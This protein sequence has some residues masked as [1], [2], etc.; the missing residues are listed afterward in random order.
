MRKE[1]RR[2]LVAD[3][4]ELEIARQHYE[5]YFAHKIGELRKFLTSLGSGNITEKAINSWLIENEV[6]DHGLK[7][8]LLQEIKSVSSPEVSNTLL[9]CRRIIGNRYRVELVEQYKHLIEAMYYTD[10]EREESESCQDAIENVVRRGLWING[11]KI[12]FHS[13]CGGFVV[14]DI[15]A[16]ALGDVGLK[17]HSAISFLN[18]HLSRCCEK[19]SKYF[20]DMIYDLK[21]LLGHDVDKCVSTYLEYDR[22][23]GIIML[24]FVQSY[25]DLYKLDRERRPADYCGD[26]TQDNNSPVIAQ[27]TVTF[28]ITQNQGRQCQI[29]LIEGFLEFDDPKKEAV[30]LDRLTQ[31]CSANLLLDE[32][33]KPLLSKIPDQNDAFII[34]D[35]VSDCLVDSNFDDII[36][37]LVESNSALRVFL[38]ARNNEN[39][40]KEVLRNY[41]LLKCICSDQKHKQYLELLKFSHS[42]NSLITKEVSLLINLIELVNEKGLDLLKDIDMIKDFFCSE[43]RYELQYIDKDAPKRVTDKKVIIIKKNRYTLEYSLTATSGEYSG[44][45]IS[46]TIPLEST[47]GIFG[48]EDTLNDEKIK[49][50]LPIVLKLVAQQGHIRQENP[51]YIIAALYT[52]T[53]S[54]I[55]GLVRLL[56]DDSIRAQIP[57]RW[58]IDLAFESSEIASWLIKSEAILNPEVTSLELCKLLKCQPQLWDAIQYNPDQKIYSLLR[59]RITAENFRYLLFENSDLNSLECAKKALCNDPELFEKLCSLK[60]SYPNELLRYFYVTHSEYRITW[61]NQ[62]N[63]CEP[64]L[65][66]H[67]DALVIEGYYRHVFRKLDLLG[68]YNVFYSVFVKKD[69]QNGSELT[70]NYA[71]K[72]WVKVLEVRCKKGWVPAFL[73]DTQEKMHAIIECMS[74]EP[75]L[76]CLFKVNSMIAE[77]LNNEDKKNILAFIRLCAESYYKIEFNDVQW[78]ILALGMLSAEELAVFFRD[79]LNCQFFINLLI[80][81]FDAINVLIDANIDVGSEVIS[82]ILRHAY[83]QM[84]LLL[85]ITVY[86]KETLLQEQFLNIKKVLKLSKDQKYSEFFQQRNVNQEE[87]V[88]HLAESFQETFRQKQKIK[89]KFEYVRNLRAKLLQSH[90]LLEGLLKADDCPEIDLA[91]LLFLETAMSPAMAGFDSRHKYQEKIKAINDNVAAVQEFVKHGFTHDDEVNKFVSALKSQK[92]NEKV[93]CLLSYLLLNAFKNNDFASM[94]I[95]S[96][97]LMMLLMEEAELFLLAKFVC[98]FG[99]LN[100]YSAPW[101][102]FFCRL[103]SRPDIYKIFSSL[104]QFHFQGAGKDINHLVQVSSEL[105]YFKA[106]DYM[107]LLL[108]EYQ[109]GGTRWCREWLLRSNWLDKMVADVIPEDLALTLLEEIK[110]R[111]SSASN[112]FS[113]IEKCLRKEPVFKSILQHTGRHC[114]LQLLQNDSTLATAIIETC[115]STIMR[116]VESDLREQLI[117]MATV[118]QLIYLIGNGADHPEAVR[119]CMLA[120]RGILHVNEE[121]ETIRLKPVVLLGLLLV[122]EKVDPNKKLGS[123]WGRLLSKEQLVCEHLL[124]RNNAQTVVINSSTLLF[125]YFPSS[126]ALIKRCL[127][128]YAISYEALVIS[129]VDIAVDFL[130]TDYC[131]VDLFER[132]NEQYTEKKLEYKAVNANYLTQCEL[133]NVANKGSHRAVN[134]IISDFRL[135][136][137]KLENE[138]RVIVSNKKKYSRIIFRLFLEC[139]EMQLERLSIQCYVNIFIDNIDK[140]ILDYKA[141]HC[142]VVPR[143]TAALIFLSKRHC[144]DVLRELFR[145][146]FLLDLVV[147]SPTAMCLLVSSP[148]YRQ[149]LELQDLIS[150]PQK[151]SMKHGSE[152][153]PSPLEERVPEQAR[154]DSFASVSSHASALVHAR[155]QDGLHLKKAERNQDSIEE[156]HSSQHSAEKSK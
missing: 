58:I 85:I 154:S 106:Q 78:V 151:R 82:S 14:H 107:K 114:L 142:V 42:R 133:V 153:S 6:S 103:A 75:R 4:R 1:S 34:D 50:L 59:K 156:E 68:F 8:L 63:V 116:S 95:S 2:V 20:S 49:P 46:G 92:E 38:V 146:R 113:E 54:E 91:C 119:S 29:E 57:T 21:L 126:S 109:Q 128:Q 108:A 25:R 36:K 89:K 12:H 74:E 150:N 137:E 115:R 72:A 24:Y 11:T 88:K 97:S 64:Y 45:C 100:D 28:R 104:L 55:P 96:P 62:F 134:K 66:R 22:I 117:T 60:S 40:L 73:Y 39:V 10:F 65:L 123:E 67:C 3:P 23:T 37:G 121:Q 87:Y 140:Y 71:K 5:D 132:M 141:R 98:L 120:L 101:L 131:V 27:S 81:N 32:S 139:T 152:N 94:I 61:G 52:L 148:L 51:L 155:E 105:G 77:Y 127:D 56:Q 145:N 138:M 41:T 102:P 99:R 26:H 19:A 143:L 111:N 48:I 47:R 43:Y 16:K 13:Q 30:L 129:N 33:K 135:K 17:S 130:L 9:R 84:L 15:L 93:R 44:E 90:E 31:R 110:I 122:S 7:T 144:N 35:F 118:E 86:S 69:F 136:K 79:T 53:V 147:S 112:S 125:R 70:I 80:K 83:P 18:I 149:S 76:I 124:N